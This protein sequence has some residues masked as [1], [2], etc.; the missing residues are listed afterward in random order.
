VGFVVDKL[1]LGQVFSEYFGFTC[2]SFHRLL[3]THL[4]QSSEA[5]AIG[6]ILTD[7]PNKIRV[8]SPYETEKIKIKTEILRFQKT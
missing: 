1:V 8:T 4:H 3:H 7:V 5:D 2:Q 6:Q